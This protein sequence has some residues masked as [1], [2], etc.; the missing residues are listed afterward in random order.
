MTLAPS[1]ETHTET[2]DLR[3]GNVTRKRVL[4]FLFGIFL[5]NLLLRVFYLR[6]DFVNGDEGIRALTAVRMLEGARLYIDVVTDKPPGTTFFY[7]A[8]FYLFG[9][10]MSAVHLAAALW[11]FLTGLTLFRIGSHL[12]NKMTGLWAALL[13]IYFSTN[14]LTH[15]M[16]AANTELLMILPYSGSLLFYLKARFI[17]VQGD[18]DSTSRRRVFLVLAGALAAVSLVFKQVG[19]FSLLFFVVYELFQAYRRRKRTEGTFRRSFSEALQ[20]LVWIG[21]GFG[22]VFTALMLLLVV[23]GTL[24]DFYRYSIELGRYYI[25][26]V[27]TSLWLKFMFGRTFGYIGLNGALWVLAGWAVVHS[28]RSIRTSNDRKPEPAANAD[29]S[30]TLW[31][32]ISLAA[33]FP[34]GRFFGHYFIQVLPALSLLGARGVSLLSERLRHERTRARAKVVAA[35]LVILFIIGL[36]RFHQ[37]TAVLAYETITGTRTASSQSWGMS[38]RQHEAEVVSARLLKLVRPADPIYVWDY[39]LDVYWITKCRPAS[40]FL[41]PYYVTGQFPEDQDMAPV[42]N[43]FWK[44]TRQLFLEDLKRE[45]PKVIVDVWGT[46]L[47]LPYPEIVEFTR[48]NY[49]PA[50]K[51]GIDPGRPFLVL[52]LKEPDPPAQLIQ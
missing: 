32:L 21:L 23:S 14:Y 37:R 24:A 16:M 40:R 30:I 20:R 35:V 18:K 26:S 15:D 39:G 41:V 48:Q 4:L 33:V 10:S 49:Q 1:Q 29:L 5:L 43:E 6:Y 45:R 22:L 36:V 34:S 7:A 38:K 9:Q 50:G 46:M 2:S 8:V 52:R 17:P 44:G 51:L 28:V 19:V 13:F 31:G 47:R 27:P 12:Y 11:N 42:D 3:R 25:S